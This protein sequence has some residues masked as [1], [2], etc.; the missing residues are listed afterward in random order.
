MVVE[1]SARLARTTSSLKKPLANACVPT[2]SRCLIC[3][4]G[5]S[6]LAVFSGG[7]VA[8]E[9]RKSIL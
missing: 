8:L 5:Y 7:V 3:S 2:Q 6:T 9:R 4:V 1:T